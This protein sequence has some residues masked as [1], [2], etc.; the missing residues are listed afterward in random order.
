[1]ENSA[2]FE[3]TRKVFYTVDSIPVDQWQ[4]V[5]GDENVY[6]SVN[7][8][9]ALETA[10]RDEISFYYT[11][12]FST[13]GEAVLCSVF[14]LVTFHD[15][16]N[17]Y[18]DLLCKLSYHLHKKLLDI[19]TINVLVCG[20]VFSDG[21]NG[22]TWS[23][24]LSD[25]EAMNEVANTVET[26][27][28]DPLIKERASIT[29]FKEFWPSSTQT[30]DHLKLRNYRDFM[31]DVNMVLK[32]HPEWRSMDDY[33]ASMTTKYRTRAKGVYKK[34]SSLTIRTLTTA[35]IITYAERIDF[36]FSNVL[37]K[38][39]FSVGGLKVD[40]FINFS[41]QLGDQFCFRA[42][43]KEG[44]MVGFSTSFVNKNSLEANF[45]GIDYDCNT[46]YAV[47]QRLLYDYV[48][49]ALYR[50]VRELQ[51]GRTAELVKSQIGALPVNMKLYVKHRK[52][53]SNLLLKP[54]VNS[55]SP[56]EFELRTPFK[57]NF[58]Q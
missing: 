50:N 43:F 35:E 14:Q 34:S 12:S 42:L 24:S 49:Q 26:L 56:S 31:I 36:L 41:K 1:M 57:A 23:S 32:I 2:N 17:S 55:I 28:K 58:T 10:M 51:L 48:E 13:E 38:A 19:Q 11:I 4:K 53:V 52:S 27:K 39:E 22:F 33:L 15:R 16:R 40:A 54:I 45:V 29:L 9:R 44:E 30:S 3:L 25:A 21:E 37:M 5:V 20:N 18:A 7:Y 8:L 6:L 47:Y 46:Q